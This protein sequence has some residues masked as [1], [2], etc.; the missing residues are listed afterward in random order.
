MSAICPNGHSSQATDYCDTCGE[1]MTV[2]PVA[3]AS[4]LSLP[5]S[6]AAA[7]LAGPSECPNCATPAAAGALF[8]ENCGYDFTT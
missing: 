3:P 8:C 5:P 1:P 7:A 6:A 2:A 4:M